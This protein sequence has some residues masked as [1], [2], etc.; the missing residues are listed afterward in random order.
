MCGVSFVI[1]VHE[2][3]LI[4]ARDIVCRMVNLYKLIF[5]IYQSMLL[6]HLPSVLMCIHSAFTIRN[7]H[8]RHVNQVHERQRNRHLMSMLIAEVIV[9]VIT[10]I[11]YSCNHIYIVT[12]QNSFQ[13]IIYHQLAS[14]LL[15]ITHKR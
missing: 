3:I 6:G 15:L 10:P 7:L 9:N 13:M 12:S 1:T 11:P 2:S 4:D 5:V 14:S 8:R